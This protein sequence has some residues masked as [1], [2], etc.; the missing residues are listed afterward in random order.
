MP[1]TI[2]GA[3]LQ[4]DTG[5]S[6][7][8]IK[9]VNTNL[10]Q[11]Q[12]ALANTSA[13]VKDTGASFSKL[14]DGLSDVHPALSDAADGVDKLTTSF[15]AM[16]ANP[17]VL[18]IVAIVGALAFLYK[19]FTNSAEGA[20]EMEQKF[21]GIKAAAQ[22]VLDA[23]F[24]LGGAIIKF[25]KGDFSGAF[26]DAKAAITGV[27]SAVVNAYNV[28]STLTKQLQDLHKEQ[29]VADVAA[30]QRGT[31]LAKLREQALDP[32][33]P[34]A[35]RKEL[36]KQLGDLED[37]AADDNIARAKKVTD[38]KIALASLEKDGVNKN[39]DEI[40]KARIELA[41]QET[42][43]E[44]EK[45]RIN[46]LAKQADKEEDATDKAAA[47]AAADAAKKDR[48]QLEAFNTQL[49]K[50]KQ[51]NVLAGI[52]DQY[53]KEKQL[54]EN[55]IADE[56][57]LI[58]KEFADSKI[59]RDQYNQLN[60][61]QAISAQAQRDALTAKHNQEV[62][63][64]ET[65]FQTQLADIKA[66]T[67]ADGNTNALTKELAQL[68]IAHQKELA[69]AITDYGANSEQFYQIKIALD[70]EYAA[71]EEA[72][73]EKSRVAAEKK[74]LDDAKKHTQTVL[75]DPKA[76]YKVR[77][78]AIDA[79]QA[80]VQKAFDAKAITESEYNDTVE[81]LAQAR[82]KIRQEE[83]A[84]IGQASSATADLLDA[85][86]DAIG[87]NTAAGKALAIAAATIKALQTEISIIAGLSDVGP[88]GFVAGIAAAAAVGVGLFNTIKQ[89]ESVAVP[90]QGSVSAP[91]V[92]SPLSISAPV[93]PSINQTSTTLNPSSINQMG[94]AQSPVRAYVVESDSAAA[95]N[96]AARL[97]NA[98]TLGGGN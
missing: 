26:D 98:A 71:K 60:A 10:D 15:K 2:I 28:A 61:Q 84:A 34:V 46:R 24:Q 72:L 1:T 13:G 18:V 92:G 35:K 70:A 81:Q 44:N 56:Q 42:D 12:K 23:I 33:V 93:A 57:V 73:K 32:D 59:T 51:Q 88:F 49:M 3:T 62:A 38:A 41:Q 4:V 69:Q 31:E 5:N 94:Q 43:A 86:G 97:S 36:I 52:T 53:A 16:L 58:A 80:Q 66:K 40:A 47:K 14:K 68:E 7:A 75:N 96:R 11:T 19:S 54:L 22:A 9:E 67:A 74:K 48:E 64:N 37:K 50:L 21:A 79:E 82:Q 76:Q 85:V 95:A 89:I 90:G 30:A 83:V 6:N 91:S 20:E 27:V 78:A 45:R 29:L 55:K 25:F 8:N 65:K 63:D 77:Q 17:I 39:R 87:K